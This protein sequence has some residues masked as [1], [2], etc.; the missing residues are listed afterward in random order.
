MRNVE[1]GNNEIT[2]EISKSHER[3]RFDRIDRRIR[4]IKQAIKKR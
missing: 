3:E 2:I 1:I 4:R